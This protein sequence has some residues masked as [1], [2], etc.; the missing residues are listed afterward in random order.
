ML[1][2]LL[3]YAARQ[4]EIR[5]PRGTSPRSSTLTKPTMPYSPTVPLS[6]A[7]N[8]A[9]T[10][11]DRNEITNSQAQRLGARSQ[12]GDCMTYGAASLLTWIAIPKEQA[13]GFA[14]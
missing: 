8:K 14:P 5:H 7:H 12:T 6:V 1:H 9:T 2:T 11:S 13:S 4:H 10:L 3:S